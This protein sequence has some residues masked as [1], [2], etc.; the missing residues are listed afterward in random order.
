MKSTADVELTLQPMT[1][2]VW[3]AW[4]DSSLYGAAGE[5]IENDSDLEG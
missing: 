2:P 3:G 4:T 1:N 5:L